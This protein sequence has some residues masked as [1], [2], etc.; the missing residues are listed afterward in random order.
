[1]S[2]DKTNPPSAPAQVAVSEL[3]LETKQAGKNKGADD[4]ADNAEAEYL[5]HQTDTAA[6]G[7]IPE[8]G[9]HQPPMGALDAEGQRPVLERSRKVR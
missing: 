9:S 7:R 2:K 8:M 6:Q 1:M 5:R 4:G 3:A